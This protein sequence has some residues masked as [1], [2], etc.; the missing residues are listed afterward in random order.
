MSSIM[1]TDD[2]YWSPQGLTCTPN[3]LSRPQDSHGEGTPRAASQ[4]SLVPWREEAILKRFFGS[5]SGKI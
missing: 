5:N 2:N 4:L 3:F 1:V